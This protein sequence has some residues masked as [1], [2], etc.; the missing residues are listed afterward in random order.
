ML[1]L[2]QMEAVLIS[3]TSTGTIINSSLALKAVYD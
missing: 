2:T 3:L 1:E